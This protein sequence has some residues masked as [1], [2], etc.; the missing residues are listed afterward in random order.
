MPW[1]L[2]ST[3]LAAAPPNEAGAHTFKQQL[4]EKP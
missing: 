4:D 1:F 3:V 2:A